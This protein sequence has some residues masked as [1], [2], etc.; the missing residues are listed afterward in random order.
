MNIIEFTADT[1]SGHII[2]P[3]EYKGI[4][5]QRVKVIL[6]P[7]QLGAGK[8]YLDELMEHPVRIKGF[9]PMTREEMYANRNFT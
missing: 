5:D 2:I 3:D 8:S 1:T 7:Q 9:K 6:L 4:V